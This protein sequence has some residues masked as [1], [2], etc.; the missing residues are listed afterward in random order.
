MDVVKQYQKEWESRHKKDE[1]FNNEIDELTQEILANA[2]MKLKCSALFD[3][4]TYHDEML[5]EKL[6]ED[7]QKFLEAFLVQ[8]KAQLIDT[9][10]WQAQRR[11]G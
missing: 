7:P 3:A 5:I 6:E 10:K 1:Q 2:D 4:M 9:A 11:V 8:Y